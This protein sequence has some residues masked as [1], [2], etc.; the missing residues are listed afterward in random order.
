MKCVKCSLVYETPRLSDDELKEF[1]SSETYYINKDLERDTSGYTDYFAQC[2]PA[3]TKKYFEILAEQN[4]KVGEIRFLDIGSGPGGVVQA[5]KGVGWRAMGL[6]LSSW[7]VAQGRK[8]GV[9]IIEGTLQDASFSNGSFDVISMFDVLEHLPYP[10]DY[11]REIYRILSPGG[12]VLVETPNV[13]GFFAK[14]LYKENSDL[15]KPRAHICLYS[16]NTAKRLF[17]SVPFSEV[18][19]ATF[20]WCRQYTPGYFKSLVV[21]RLK[22]VGKPTQLTFNESMR[23]IAWK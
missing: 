9:D 22:K 10:I 7:A 18:N 19:T 1:Y 12:M 17:D 8:L 5:A 14:H 16:P 20:P 6:E 11:I 4:R 23:V 13:E 15:V 21:S 2:S 3:L